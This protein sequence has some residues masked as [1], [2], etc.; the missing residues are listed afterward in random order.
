MNA[1]PHDLAALDGLLAVQPAWAGVRTASDALGLK[2]HTLLHCGPPADPSHDLATPILNSA[3]VACVF[4]GWAKNFDEADHLIA[5][6]AIKFEPAQDR[7]TA[8]PMAAVVSPAMRL[9][10]FSD[11]NGV[12]RPAYAPLNGGGTGAAP[13]P[14]Y[15]RKSGE[16]LELLGFLN[17]RVA[18]AIAPAAAEPI[19]WLPIIDDAL[20]NGDDGHLRHVAAHRALMAVLR[21]RA[22]PGFA[23][24]DVED[25]IAQWPIFH[26]NFWMAGSKCVLGGAAGIEGS[27][28]ITGFG[29]NGREFGLQVSGL[30][31]RWFTVEAT[32]P[33]GNLRG[34]HTPET[35]LGAFGDSALAEAL[36]LG[37]MA[38]SY[39]P[40][41]Q[42][43]HRDFSPDDILDLPE[44]LLAARHPG[45]AKS[46]ARV[47]CSVRIVAA[48]GVT[49][50]VELG[51]VDKAGREGGLGAGIYRPPLAPFM[52]ACRALDGL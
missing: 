9:L 44:K 5:S 13:A 20:M 17:D 42:A 43:L 24:G 4:E 18:D 35:C 1:G 28:I 26:L 46:G 12:A 37:A 14:R 50:V 51:I 23:G 48:A 52:A 30:P 29:G 22:A 38:Q 45:L 27:G 40:D 10:Q 2:S 39:C 34:P 16:A 25:F 32:P 19:E 47:G 6:G 11:L 36:G 3:A 8:V 21:D 49:P 7:S 31:G 33:L 41:M 15:G